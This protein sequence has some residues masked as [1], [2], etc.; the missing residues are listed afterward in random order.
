M[1]RLNILSCLWTPFARSGISIY[2]AGA[3]FY[4]MLS[5]VPTAALFFSSLPYFHIEEVYLWELL[6]GI[7]PT[8]FHPLLNVLLKG[9]YAERS[10]SVLSV[11][12]IVTLWSASKGILALMDGLN[13]TLSQKLTEGYIRRHALAMLYFIVLMLCILVILICLV[14]G[15]I[16]FRFLP[17]QSGLAAILIRYR[18]VSVLLFLSAVFSLIYRLLP[19]EK[20]PYQVCLLSGFLSALGWIII[21]Y[22]FSLYIALIAG[23]SRFYGNLSILLFAGLW[24]RL[25]ASVFLY[26]GLYGK[27][28]NEGNY[29]P[30]KIL[31]AFIKNEA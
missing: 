7:L 31:R 9:I 3:S 14:F 2:A 13:A 29:H 16:V 8:A 10:L 18:M 1:K 30:L 20:I 23:R 6:I 4:L 21:S 5:V 12:A 15:R 25:C 22:G 27:L 28:K 11:S 24:L 26:G 19:A 17:V